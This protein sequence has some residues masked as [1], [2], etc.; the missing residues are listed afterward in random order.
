MDTKYKVTF[1]GLEK[2]TTRVFEK[3]GWMVLTK[4]EANSNIDMELRKDKQLK[5]EGFGRELKHLCEALKEKMNNISEDDRKKDLI[6]L[7]EKVIVLSKFFKD[8][9]L[10]NSNVMG[11]G[12]KKPKKQSKK[13]SKKTMKK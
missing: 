3:F 6:I 7:Y 2:W 8:Y 10:D 5:L 1:R 12:S 13:S 4:K 9:V 11:G